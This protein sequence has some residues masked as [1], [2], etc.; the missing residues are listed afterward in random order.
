MPSTESNRDNRNVISEI[1]QKKRTQKRWFVALVAGVFIALGAQWAVKHYSG[2]KPLPKEGTGRMNSDLA[3]NKVSRINV[4]PDYLYEGFEI[5]LKTGERYIT[6]GP[7]MD[8]KDARELQSKGVEV[9]FESPKTDLRGLPNYLLIGV[10]FIAMCSSLFQS[11]GIGFPK[12]EKQSNKKFSDVAG[13]SEAKAAFAEVVAYLRNPQMYEKV[14]ARFPKGIIMDGPPGTGKTLMAQAVAGEAN[15][16][17]M[18]TSGS[19]FSSMFM[20]MSGVK[21]RTFFARARRNAPCVVFIDEIDAI[22]GK[23]LSEGT[24]IAREMGSTLNQL[25]VQMDGFSANNGV[26]VIAATNRIELLDP[27]LLR[28][29]RFDRQIHM[30]LPILSERE[31]ILHIHGKKLSSK[32]FDYA[33]VAKACIG[34]SGA[35]LENLVNQAALICAGEGG[36]VVTTSHG[37]AARNRMRMGDA[38]HVQAKS[39]TDE[40]RRILATHECGHALVGMVNGMDPVTHVSII[41]RGQSL[42]Q[43]MMTPDEERVLH[44]KHHLVNHIRLLLGG[45]AAEVL[46]TKTLTTG[47]SDDLSKAS[48]LALD[49]IG[50]YGMSSSLLRVT[51][52][53]SDS[54]RF[55]VE[56]EANELLLKLMSEAT[57]IILDHRIL[58]E[59]MVDKL[60]REEEIDAAGMEEMYA[61]LLARKTS[62]ISDTVVP[63][64]FA[65]HVVRRSSL[66]EPEG[67]EM[68]ASFIDEPPLV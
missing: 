4:T 50:S 21:I 40:T 54:L 29:G 48:E 9:M 37:L 45:R 63:V 17:F 61:L 44:E 14:G 57:A 30:Q 53:S 34:M 41:P 33:T 16:H 60:E 22:G 66:V 32:E 5:T 19:D 20:A 27:A 6:S 7:H 52:K 13:N 8:A 23:R 39:F 26:I 43:T 35:D 28:S 36:T 42:G 3:A 64:D 31:E 10:I 47:A 2:E 12:K 58:F 24:A 11:M 62:E 25:L 1:V 46:V 51:E 65:A 59:A 56:K 18:S 49:M 68:T 38:R 67:L 15:A 55:A